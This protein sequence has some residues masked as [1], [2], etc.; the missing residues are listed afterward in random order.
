MWLQACA[1]DI[2]SPQ[3]THNYMKKHAKMAM[4]IF[5]KTDLDKELESSFCLGFKEWYMGVLGFSAA[6]NGKYSES[7]FKL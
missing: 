3:D 2:V 1:F 5:D 6:T 4:N 7:A